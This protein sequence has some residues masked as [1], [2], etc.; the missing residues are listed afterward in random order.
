M[1]DNDAHFFTEFLDDFFAECDEHLITIRR[2]LL[3]LEPAPQQLDSQALDLLLRSFHTI[4]G[5]AGMVGV[6][7]VEQVAHHMEDYLRALRSGQTWLTNEGLRLLG[8]GAGVIEQVLG[9]YQMKRPAPDVAPIIQQAIAALPSQ[10]AVSALLSPAPPGPAQPASAAQEQA[11]IDE[12]ARQGVSLWEVHFAP[13]AELTARG[14]NVNSVRAQLEA[15]GEIVR[16]TPR[17]EGPGRLRFDFLLASEEDLARFTT[18]AEEGLSYEPFVQPAPAGLD[19]PTPVLS[20]PLA[21]MS[22][23]RVDLTRIDAVIEVVGELVIS[24][25][26]LREQLQPLEAE[27][28][29]PAWRALQETMLALERQLRDLRQGVMHMRLVSIGEIFTR[30]QFAARELADDLNKGIAVVLDGETTEID[31]FIVERMHDPLLHLVRNAA[32]HGLEHA[33]ERL[34]AGKPARGTIG[35]RA[36]TTGDTV[37]IAI[38]DDGRGIDAE[39]VWARGRALGLLHADAPL[40]QAALLELLCAP[41]FS[42]RDE[43]DR[44]SGRGVGMDVVNKTVQELGGALSLQTEAGRGTCFTIDLPLTVAIADALIVTT[45]GQTFAVPMPAVRE[46]IEVMPEAITTLEKNELIAYRTG[47]LP[48][49]RLARRF[50][51]AGAG[52]RHYALIVGAGLDAVGIA[53][54]QIIGKREIVVRPLS[55]P[56][57]AIDGLAGA[58]ELGDGRPIF[59]LD[60]ARLARSPRQEWRRSAPPASL[61]PT[62]YPGGAR[63]HTKEHPMADPQSTSEQFVLFELA[64]ATYGLPSRLVRHMELVEQLTPV[65]NAIAYLAGVVFSRG[66]VLPAVDLRARFGFERIPYT[67]RTRMIVVESDKRTI[68]LIVDTARE[69]VTLRQDTIQDPPEA[70]SGLSGAYLRGIA[71][72]NDRLVLLLDLDEVLHGTETPEA[73]G[74]AE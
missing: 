41:G 62:S 72:H 19:A 6:Q 47:A 52:R 32:S 73:S 10:P 49:V 4:K 64:G 39:R 67:L 58:A 66:Q 14:V 31:K 20:R 56:L 70:I 1:V 25:S 35:L 7:A 12:L 40:D 33:D 38:E 59:I 13:T 50:G 9:A 54:D 24:R 68:G 18:W 57:L 5:L 36:T 44:V 71:R 21:A 28:A 30:M 63:R 60:A 43:A 22:V 69:F 42:T 55:D 15:V 3:A 2:A 23:V 8:G 11:R 34:A 29:V 37:T 27:V 65:P 74:E 16:A 46:I 61:R 53:V 48:L 45:A 26:R 17:M 51:L